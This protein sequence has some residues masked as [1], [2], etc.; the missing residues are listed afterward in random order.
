MDPVKPNPPDHRR[1]IAAI[2]VLATILT[3]VL[4]VELAQY[5]GRIF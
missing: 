2:L 5:L 3:A 1:I 4:I